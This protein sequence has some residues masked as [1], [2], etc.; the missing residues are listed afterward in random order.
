MLPNDDGRICDVGTKR[1]ATVEDLYHVEEDGKAEI[2]NGEVVVM[3]RVG[4]A[5]GYA[6]G[7]IF[8]SL[9]DYAKRTNR[10]RAVPNPIAFTVNLPTRR[11]FSPGAAFHLDRRAAF[12]VASPGPGRCFSIR[13]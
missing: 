2:V 13:Q 7:E 9:R 5:H 3:E 6:S 11:S 4:D 1:E 10:G 8:A 12:G